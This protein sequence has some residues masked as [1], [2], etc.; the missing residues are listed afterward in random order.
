MKRLLVAAAL[1][2]FIASP[3]TVAPARAA[4]PTLKLSPTYSGLSSPVFL[5]GARD[6]TNRRF[7]VQQGGQIKVS[8]AGK[9]T[10]QVYLDLTA[11]VATGGE[12]GLLGLAFHPNFKTNKQ[13]YV[14]YTRKSDGDIVISE[15]K[16]LTA[17]AAN[18]ASEKILAVIE[19]SQ[20]SNH[21]GGML[22]FGPD[23][24]LYI[25][26]GDGG[27]QN[28][29]SNHA[30]T[31]NDPLGKILRIDV[32]AATPT[33]QIYAIG[34]RNPWRFSFDRADGRLFVGD[35]GQSAREEV[36]IVTQGANYGW[37]VMEGTFC[38][39]N[40][41]GACNDPSFTPPIAEYADGTG[42]CSITGG[43]VY[44]GGGQAMPVGTYLFGDYCTG[45]IFVIDGGVPAVALDTTFNISSFG[46][47]DGGEL[48][49][50]NL[51]GTI[52]KLVRP[53]VAPPPCKLPPI[54]CR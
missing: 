21:N 22:A 34:F 35:V 30:Q 14:N 5:T 38:T 52:S 20:F 36:D 37:R 53:G 13:F 7:I 23:G 33:L 3:L 51:N 48:Y 10:T 24:R 17:N 41:P 29:P 39:G 42:R 15:F 44:R 18:P 27:S 19:H 47:D 1:L 46:Q 25:G 26:S 43:Y 31:P 32:N 16:G 54:L 4:V 50:V 45:E 6:G 49:V 28:D 8:P 2:A 9:T 11:K 12:R 40:G